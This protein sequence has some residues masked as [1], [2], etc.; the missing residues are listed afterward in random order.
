MGLVIRDKDFQCIAAVTGTGIEKRLIT[1]SLQLK[2]DAVPAVKR[3]QRAPVLIR[4]LVK[5]EL[6]R[7]TIWV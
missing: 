7:L 2:P 3:N 4:P 5:T 6:I 1:I